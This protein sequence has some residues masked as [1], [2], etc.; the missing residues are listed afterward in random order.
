MLSRVVVA[1]TGRIVAEHMRHSVSARERMRGLRAHRSLVRGEA[2]L[3]TPCKQVH[4]F[5]M[6]FPIDVVF[7]DRGW[8]VIRVTRGMRPGRVGQLVC[9]AR[10]TI[11]LAE[12]AA[13]DVQIGDRLLIEP[14]S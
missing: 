10:Y 2:L 12:G 14:R 4:T 8:H 6:R 9:R 11:E 1:D 13:A 7:C 3:L 5:G